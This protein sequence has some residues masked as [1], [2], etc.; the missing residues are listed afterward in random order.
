MGL[1]EN[2]LSVGSGLH[3]SSTNTSAHPAM[4][5]LP[6]MHKF[7]GYPA[8]LEPQTPES[9]TRDPKQLLYSAIQA[10]NEFARI[11]NGPSGQTG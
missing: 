1:E 7:V 9:R 10:H 3:A 4:Q 5:S 6:T 11:L 2:E 8:N